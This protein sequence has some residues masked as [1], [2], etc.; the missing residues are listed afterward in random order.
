VHVHCLSSGSDDPAVAGLRRTEALD[1]G[2]VLGVGGCTFSGIRDTRFADERGSINQAVFAQLA[3]QRPDVVYTHY[4]RDQHLDHVVT[5]EEVTVA[6]LREVANLTY[7]RSPYSRGMEPN[8]VFMGSAELL[9]VKMAA[10]SC[11]SSQ[12]QLDMTVFRNLSTVAHRQFVHHRVVERFPEQYVCAEQF[13]VERRIEF[14][15][16]PPSAA[17]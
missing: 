2:R 16:D 1:A 10:L 17:G 8:L 11:Y 7:F 4:P 13:R 14:A 5:G 9:E 3:E 15:H 6:A 12:A